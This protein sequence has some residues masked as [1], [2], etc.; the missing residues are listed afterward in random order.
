MHL[1][2]LPAALLCALP[3]LALAADP[4]SMPHQLVTTSR[5]AQDLDRSLAA[6]TLIERADIERLQAT[7]LAELL[8]RVPGVTLANNGGPGK[9]T[10][11][12]MRGSNSTHTLLLI[13]GVRIGSATSGAAALQD[14]PVE[15]I[16]RIE[17]VRGPRSSLYG[18]EAI[19]GVIHI[20]TRREERAGLRPF[21]SL[22]TASRDTH[23]ASAGLSARQ[24]ASWFNLG[25]AASDTDAIDAKTRGSSGHEDDRDGYRSRSLSL[26][27]GHRLNEAIE[28]EGSFLQA[29]SRNHYD[30]LSRSG[31]SGLDAHADGLQRVTSLAAHLRPL[32]PWQMTLRAG[33]SEDRS[34]AFQDARFFSRFASERDSLSW[35]NDI[36]LGEGHILVLGSDYLRDRID[37][38]TAYQ[39]DSRDNHGYFIQYLGSHQRHDW[40]WALRRDVDEQFGD[41]ETG[42]LAWGY[43]LSEDLRLYAS[44]GTAF[45]APTFNQ[46]YFPGFGN[47]ALDAETSQSLELGLVGRSDWGQWSASVYRTHIDDLIATVTVDGRSQALGVDEARLRGLELS[48]ASRW[49]GWD[50]QAAYSLV[51]AENRSDR[52]SRSGIAYYGKALNRRPARTLNLD[53]DRRFGALTLGAGVH[54]QSRRYDDLENQ[55]PLAGFVTLDL[56]GE[57][58]FSPQWRLQ[59]KAANL[60]NAD[61]QTAAGFEQPAQSLALTL[62]YQAL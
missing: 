17:V 20:F 43:A 18:S 14:L 38:T 16:E 48:L 51:D 60:L 31:T 39:Q 61:Y 44:A 32:D 57:W 24:G 2:V 45:K 6:V 30:A 53:I 22:G 29:D 42:S 10:S 13:D 56:R 28:L 26:R 23:S 5:T 36:Q 47:P 9:T 41:H 35:Q 27:A 52:R 8:Q 4:L 37:S 58:Q 1:P 7:S 34:D 40:Q 33:R 11:L 62:R 54:A 59:L 15:L 50:W 55:T 19:G 21:L 49:L 12:F 25:V 3:S 46:L